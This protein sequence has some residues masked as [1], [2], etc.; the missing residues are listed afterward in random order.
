MI[1]NPENTA[2]LVGIFAD[3]LTGALDAAAPFAARGFRTLVS[4]T[5]DLPLDAASVD[6]VSVNLGTRHMTPGDIA[7][8][9]SDA[10]LA[11][12]SLGIQIF[13]N[14]IDSTLRGNPG[15]ELA[16]AMQIV[17]VDQSILCS[18]YPQNGRVIKDGTLLVDGAPVMETDV[19]QDPLSPLSSSIVEEILGVSLR[20]AGLSE[21]VS[22]SSSWSDSDLTD[23]KPAIVISDATSEADIRMLAN[24]LMDTTETALVAGSAGIAVALAEAMSPEGKTTAFVSDPS[25]SKILVVTG[26]Q[27]SI[28]RRQISIL[29]DN[30]DLAQAEVPVAELM[31]GISSASINRLA[32]IVDDWSVTVLELGTVDVENYDRLELQAMASEI[33]GKLG[34]L[35]REIADRSQIDTF[36]VIGG[37]TAA[38]VLNACGVG[39]ILIQ[40]E[41]QPGTVVGRPLDGSIANS[42]LVTRAGGFGNENSLT[43]LVL[44]LQPALKSDVDV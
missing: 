14:K 18:A 3:D 39:S 36:V 17:A 32:S 21:T 1:L 26:S 9:V 6:V 20:R 12:K 33:V 24:R 16:S 35:V 10:V 42:L 4:P 27:R 34:Q 30:V 11:L 41:L 7:D 22:I 19:G 25:E 29:G 13:L 37:D 44:L 38:G 5:Y 40:G 43:E 8:R 23:R 15:V 2:P 31:D 28:V